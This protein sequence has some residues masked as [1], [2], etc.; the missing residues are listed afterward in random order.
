MQIK[1]IK[2]RY[3]NF[4]DCYDIKMEVV[5]LF[6]IMQIWCQSHLP[7]TNMCHIL[8]LY[9][10]TARGRRGRD[11]MVVGFITTYPINQCISPLMLWVLISIRAR[12]ATLC[13]KVC[14]WLVTGRW[15]SPGPP[16]SSNNKTDRHDI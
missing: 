16:V 1:K 12:C 14:Q 2:N 9:M 4:I 10:V 7:V 3:N 8:L 11:R 13:D 6:L 5:K 15:F